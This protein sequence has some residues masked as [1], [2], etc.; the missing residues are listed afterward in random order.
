MASVA[1]FASTRSHMR[2]RSRLP[3]RFHFRAF[4]ADSTPAALEAAPIPSTDEIERA[5]AFTREPFVTE[6]EDPAVA[7]APSSAR[8]WALDAAL[9]EIEAGNRCPSVQWRRTY[10]LLLGLERLLAQDE[11]VLADGTVLSAHQVD[12]LSGTL[13]ALL[14]EAQRNGDSPGQA[15]GRGAEEPVLAS[16]AIPGEEDLE[17]EEP[18]EE[19]MDWS[20]DGGEPLVEEAPE[21]P[22]AG[23]RFWFEHATGAGKTVAALGFV[24]ASRTGGVLSSWGSCGTAA[25]AVASPARGWV[26]TSAATGR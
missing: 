13:T 26:T 16:P 18:D 24:E 12:A 4:M 11:P 7:L 14:A 3:R 22:N 23:R 25:I 17:D 5:A 21:D 19:P 2:L 15:N 9:A 20:D 1:E 10:S 6:G 8:R